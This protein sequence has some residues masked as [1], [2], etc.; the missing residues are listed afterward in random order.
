MYFVVGLIV[1]FNYL[2]LNFM[3][4]QSGKSIYRP[5][6]IGLKTRRIQGLYYDTYRIVPFVSRYVSI[7]SMPLML[8]LYYAKRYRVWVAVLLVY[9]NTFGT[10]KNILLILGA[11]ISKLKSIWPMATDL[12]TLHDLQ[13]SNW[14]DI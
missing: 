14:R 6:Y 9:L 2:L 10:P 8:H 7:R 4:T 1:L 11:I 3:N 12:W 5:I 13:K